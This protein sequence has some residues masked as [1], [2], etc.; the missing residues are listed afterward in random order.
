MEEDKNFKHIIRIA[1]TDLAGNKPINHALKKIKGIGFM[2]ANMV[3]NLTNVDRT[4][5][6]GNLSNHEIDAINTF[7]TNPSKQG[8]PEWMLNRRRDFQTGEAKHLVMGDLKF[9]KENDV[10]KLKKIKSYVGTRH[11]FGLPS[12]GQKTKSNFRKNK[13]KVQGVKK[14]AGKKSGK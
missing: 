7:L 5:K 13:G 4:K 2:F 6:A 1:N 11:M 10:R 9:T 8:A 3:C 12:R 14:K